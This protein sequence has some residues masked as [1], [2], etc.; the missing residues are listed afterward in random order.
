ME[1]KNP[2]FYLL[3]M[4]FWAKMDKNGA[5]CYRI[6]RLIAA[7]SAILIRQADDKKGEK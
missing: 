4:K 6:A 5:L 7:S 1:Q 3:L 2:Y